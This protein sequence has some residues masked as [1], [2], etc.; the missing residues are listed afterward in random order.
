M[1][2]AESRAGSLPP[3]VEVLFLEIMAELP[4]IRLLLT[5]RLWRQYRYLGRIL[6]GVAAITT[7]MNSCVSIAAS[8]VT[9]IAF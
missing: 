7:R 8:M 2:L 9:L 4:G 3:I 5:S 6:L 1:P